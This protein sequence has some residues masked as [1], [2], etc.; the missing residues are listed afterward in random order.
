METKNPAKQKDS[1]K[2]ARALKENIL[3]KSRIAFALGSLET[4]NFLLKNEDPIILQKNLEH[5]KQTIG[6]VLEDL[7]K[8]I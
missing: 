2:L 8:E 4:V 5:L 1:E 3:L 6:R 7:R